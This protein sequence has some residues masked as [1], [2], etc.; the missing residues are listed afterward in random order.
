[1]VEGTS[2]MAITGPGV[3]K[4]VTGEDVTLEELGGAKVHSEITGQ[5]HLTAEN[6]AA[7]IQLIRELLAFLPSNH[8]ETPPPLPC[9]DDVNRIDNK[10]EEIV[11]ASFRKA[12]DM[13]QLVKR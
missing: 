6:D 7:C 2:Q 1:M 11:P 12:Y 8:L 10:L 3:I 9:E 5:A 4:S 13:R